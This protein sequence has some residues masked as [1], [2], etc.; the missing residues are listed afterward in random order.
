MLMPNSAMFNGILIYS[1]WAGIDGSQP[2]GLTFT[3]YTRGVVGNTT[4]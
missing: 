1:F 2:G 3:N 4:P